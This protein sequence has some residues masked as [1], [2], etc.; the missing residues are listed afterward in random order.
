MIPSVI[1]A[2]VTNTLMFTTH[3]S[4]ALTA[5][6]LLSPATCEDNAGSSKENMS[7]VH[8]E[9]TEYRPLEPIWVRV[10]VSNTTDKTWFLVRN[11]KT[12]T[13][14]IGVEVRKDRVPVDQT[15]F[16]KH[17]QS[18]RYAT[19]GDLIRP[20]QSFTVGMCVNQHYDMTAPGRYVMRFLVPG[21]QGLVWTDY[22][23]VT[24]SGRPIRPGEEQATN[25]PHPPE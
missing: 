9:R 21:E 23:R 4:I 12:H 2:G 15:S 18:R 7:E 17:V 5:A 11:N 24:I 16:H 8:L 19:E 1:F 14:D 20:G 13:Y 6:F 22:V 3:Y 10:N 25:G